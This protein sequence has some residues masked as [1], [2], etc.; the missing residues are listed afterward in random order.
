MED[1][2]NKNTWVGAYEAALSDCHVMMVKEQIVNPQTGEVTDK[3]RMV[4]IEKWYKFSAKDKAVSMS[5]EEI[6]KQEKGGFALSRWALVPQSEPKKS[7]V[8]KW[9]REMETQ[10]QLKQMAEDSAMRS[11]G[12]FTRSGRDDEEGPKRRSKD[13]DDWMK[14]EAAPDADIIDYDEKEEFA[15]DEEGV[16]GLFEGDDETTKD[17]EEKIKREQLSANFFANK[18]EK[19]VWQ[20]EE[21]EAL[22]AEL[23]KK[24]EK[25]LRKKIVKREKNYNYDLDDSD[26]N[27]YSEDVSDASLIYFH[28]LHLLTG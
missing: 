3:Y 16:N 7:S 5:V 8:P 13:D 23:K 4:P 2:D 20:Q 11:K 24:L 26:A 18:E 15:D 17:A 21:E 27:P 12:L 1:F 25:S 14:T 22:E 9:M 6:E 10:K 19:D 28:A